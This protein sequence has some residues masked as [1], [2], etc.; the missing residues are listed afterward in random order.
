[1]TSAR[2]WL[3][4]AVIVVAV[5]I[6][7]GAVV[8]VALPA[9]RRDIAVCRSPDGSRTVA[10]VGQSILLGAGGIEILVEVR[11]GNG[12]GLARPYV[13]GMAGGWAEA[14]KNFGLLCGPTGAVVDGRTI[15][16][17]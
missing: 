17:K 2:N 15:R 6:L 8:V 14:R 1:M 5:F 7:L 4:A 3:I 10:V 12:P 11:D 9:Q 13:I 16:F